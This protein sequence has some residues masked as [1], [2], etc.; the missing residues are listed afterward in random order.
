[1]GLLAR[2]GRIMEQVVA[3]HSGEA[4]GSG[5]FHKILRDCQLTANELRELLQKP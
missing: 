3:A 2:V 5:L 1:M 4:I